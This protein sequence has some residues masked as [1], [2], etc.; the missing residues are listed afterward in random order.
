MTNFSKYYRQNHTY[1]PYLDTRLQKIIEKIK[2]LKPK[3][4]LDIGCGNGLLLKELIKTHKAHYY[5]VDVYSNSKTPYRYKR[6]DITKKLPFQNA[7]FDCVILGEVIEHVPD[8]DFVLTEIHRVLKRGGYLI[9]ST[10]NLVSWA[11]RILVILGIQ[12]FF[13]ETSSHKKLGRYFTFLGQ[14]TEAQ[15][16]L[17]IFTNKSLDE[18]LKM[19]KFTV[20]KRCGVPFFFP[21]PISYIDSFF[22]NFISL[23]SGLLYV[24]KRKS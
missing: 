13:T 23:A 14:N 6:A 22:T 7:S 11:N 2:E 1:L 17:K 16:H 20:I 24:A 4:I 18:I 5:G 19:Y 21:K 10:P 8:P 3:N 15:G 12:P 9:V